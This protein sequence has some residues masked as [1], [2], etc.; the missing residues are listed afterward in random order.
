MFEKV[1]E[2]S[3]IDLRLGPAT[4]FQEKVADFASDSYFYIS[5]IDSRVYMTRK[6][7]W[8][9]ISGYQERGRGGEI[10]LNNRAA[11]IFCNCLFSLIRTL[12]GLNE[13]LVGWLPAK[14]NDSPFPLVS[15]LIHSA[16]QAGNMKICT[17]C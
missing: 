12:R 9:A 16:E 1:S 5:V 13:V 6:S 10:P 2:P 4:G 3:L 15:A 7:R 8:S 14:Q 17:C 11:N